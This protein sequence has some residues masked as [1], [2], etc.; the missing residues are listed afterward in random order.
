[1]LTSP[2]SKW[3]ALPALLL[4]AAAAWWVLRARAGSFEGRSAAEWSLDLAQNSAPRTAAV[5]NALFVLGPRAVPSL[6]KQLRLRESRVRQSLLK[7]APKLP[8]RA[9]HAMLKRLG[10]TDAATC[11]AMAA[12][13][14]G[15]LETNALAAIPNLVAAFGDASP[16]VG[17]EA[18]TALGRIGEPALPAV[19]AAAAD[20]HPQ[21]RRGA[22]LALSRLSHRVKTAQPVL[23]EA[24]HD[25]DAGVRSAAI[26][27]LQFARLLALTNL[28]SVLEQDRSPRRETAARAL[29]QLFS[30]PQMVAPP[31]LEMARDTNP[32]VRLTAV[33]CLPLVQPWTDQVFRVLLNALSDPA[34]AVR[35]AATNAFCSPPRKMHYAAP[36]LVA[37]LDD[38]SAEARLWAAHALGAVP[39]PGGTNLTALEARLPRETDPAVRDALAS[40]IAA[41]RGAP[42]RTGMLVSPPGK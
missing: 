34:P 42:G 37:A 21:V 6:C 41:L 26:Q 40:S 18:A 27:G 12:R 25:P 13:A 16:M 14:L 4:V 32:A 39:V 17:S 2:R 33:E 35:A 38:P 22:V 29:V 19:V 5:S 15:M 8:F 24:V 7:L 36:L 1:M 10:W 20:S 31:L 23:L 9:R 3:L 28:V 30:P 11:R